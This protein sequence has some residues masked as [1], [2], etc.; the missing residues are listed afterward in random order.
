MSENA[1]VMSI[2][3]DMS[4]LPP[5]SVEAEQAVLGSVLLDGNLWDIVVNELTEIDFYKPEH[6]S[7]YH[8]LSALYRDGKVMDVITVAE[9]LEQQGE[10]EKIGGMYSLVSLTESIPVSAHLSTYTNIVRKRS[11][12]R[13]LA[14]E[15]S[16][17]RNMVYKPEGRTVE[18]ILNTAEQS[19][20][21]IAE[22]V[23]SRLRT[24]QDINEIVA[25]AYERI[26][27]IYENNDPITGLA[28]GFSDLDKQTA[29]FQ[30][31]DLV[32]IAGRPS[33]GKTALA[34]NIAEYAACSNKKKV[35]IFSMEMS[36][37]QLAIRM[38]SSLGRIDQ[39]K[40]RTG[41]LQD[42]DWDRLI[43]ATGHLSSTN[44]FVDDTPSLSPN[45]I[46]SRCR[47]LKRQHDL[48]LVI[49]DYLQLMGV[50]STNENRATEISEISRSLKMMAKELSA[51]VVALSQLNRG[52]ENRSE[53]RPMMSDLR[54]S[55]AIEQDADLILFIYRDEVYN[56]ESKAGGV[57][58]IIIGKQR[59]G[60]IGTVKLSFLSRYTRFEN[61]AHE[62][63]DQGKGQ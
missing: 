27:K 11:V 55:G 61:L 17:I 6:R 42:R 29:G 47:R 25:S 21:G 54:E 52:L 35:A 19:I 26:Q 41:Q 22:Q 43:S 50:P 62:Y 51:P 9:W 5:H 40:V 23:D 45:E 60:P 31:S 59:N 36:A 39:Q 20:F 4:G 10:L 28:T 13:Q 24:Q 18:E 44:I 14:S 15:V 57:A 58:E 33:M 8:A 1:K 48:D 46:R 12:L 2:N 37:E 53:K 38:L 63:R 7:I 16:D 56:K 30:D 34:I 49:I 3:S 32:I